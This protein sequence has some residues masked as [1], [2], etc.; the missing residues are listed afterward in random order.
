MVKV[1]ALDQA[2][3]VRKVFGTCATPSQGLAIQR[4]MN[5]LNKKAAEL[6]GKVIRVVYYTI[7]CK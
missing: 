6:T 1:I 7:R 2:T 3:G 5:S 4:H